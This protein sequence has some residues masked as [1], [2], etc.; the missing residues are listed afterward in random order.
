MRACVVAGLVVSCARPAPRAHT[1]PPGET[2]ALPLWPGNAETRSAPSAFFD[3]PDLSQITVSKHVE[4]E[5]GSSNYTQVEVLRAGKV[6]CDVLT[7]QNGSHEN[8]R[9]FSR[10]DIVL[11]SREPV[12]FYLR[13]TTTSNELPESARCTGYELPAS[14]TC[15]TVFEHACTEPPCP[16][17]YKASV[18]PG[19]GVVRGVITQ[20]GEPSPGMTVT[21]G[22]QVAISD[23][24]GSFALDAGSGAHEVVLYGTGNF[25]Q[26]KVPVTTTSKQDAVLAVA[27][28]CR[29][30]ERDPCCVP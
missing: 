24:H 7:A 13:E 20:D 25:T 2:P 14:G 16:L 4:D 21:V 9:F 3:L 18:V 11:S 28:A 8:H 1:V 12:R 15:R 27:V 19:T 17:T 6:V 26:A 10:G 30:A 5:W 29:T 23:E 22:S